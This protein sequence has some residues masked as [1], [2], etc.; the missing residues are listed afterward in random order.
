MAKHLQ[1]LTGIIQTTQGGLG[2]VPHPDFKD[3][4][5]IE[6]GY[7]NTALNGDT[8]EVALHQRSK[9]NHRPKGEVLRVIKRAK[10]KFVGVLEHEKGFCFL[11]PDDRRMYV[12]IL[13]PHPPQN[14]PSGHKVLVEMTDWSNPAKDPVG[15]VLEVLGPQ[16]EHE[17]EIRSIVLERGIDTTFPKD[18]VQE[19]QACKTQWDTEGANYITQSI[20]DKSRRD[21][22]DIPTCTID[23]HDAKDFDDALSYRKLSDG[24]TEVGIHIADVSYFVEQGSALDEE[25]QQRGFSTYLVDR[26][27]PMLP[28][29]LSNDL[30]SLNPNTDRLTFS[31]VFVL[32]DNAEIQ[33]KWFG[34]GVIHSDKRFSYEEAQHILDSGNGPFKEELVA[35]NT[36][37]QKLRT[38]RFQE[39]SIDFATDEVEVELD[40]HNKPVKI[41]RKALLD[42]NKM[43]EDFMLLA[44]REVAERI[45]KA[46]G[47]KNVER[48]FIYRVHD[49]PDKEKLEQLQIMLHALGY[50]LGKPGHRV[51]AKQIN[52]LL[53]EI[54]GKPIENTISTA[55]IRSMSKAQYDTENIGHFGLG[56]SYY[57]HFTSPIRRYSDLLV[58]RLL[59]MHLHHKQVPQRT[60]GE[61]KQIAQSLSQKEITIQSAER[62]SIKY[63]QVEYMQTRI[64][65]QFKGIIS[66]VTEWGLYIEE[67]ETGAEGL[68][69]VASLKDDYYTFD[70]R[71]YRLVG[72]RT[73]KVYTLGDTVTVEVVEANVDKRT[74][75]YLIV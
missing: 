37:S 25:A 13:I 22:R 60:F 20:A 40:E 30:C 48:A 21:F 56:F 3:D 71:H 26:T 19:A 59:H 28:E 69:R 67:K 14:V 68:V 49:H 54:E 17:I 43:I 72:K 74:I 53:R 55:L 75:D 64:G 38:K 65:Q 4:I 6:Q 15:T 58:H 5:R 70:E 45:F 8:V 35:L 61:Y 36:L 2:F 62:E 57:T 9:H 73:K 1:K 12:D 7:L 23:P 24:T 18:V 42:T 31:A 41:Y 47:E 39:G 33:N 50:D 44:N 52:T 16:G 10:Q 51:S 63:K 11:V 66:G 34:R 46:H 27:I 32:N 29:E